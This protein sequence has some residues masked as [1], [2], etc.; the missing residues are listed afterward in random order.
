[1]DSYI[2]TI[3]LWSASYIPVGWAA[4]NGAL[5]PINQNYAA[6]ALLGT[7]YG[8]DGINTFALPNLPKVTDVDGYGVSQYII[9]LQGYFPPH[10]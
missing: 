10:P 9:C 7:T 8:G 2:G 1:M 5:L 3:V 6:F 4:C